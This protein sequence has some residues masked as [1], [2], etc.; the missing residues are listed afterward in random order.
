MARIGKRSTS[1]GSW[2]ATVAA[3]L[4]LGFASNPRMALGGAAPENAQRGE[5][6]FEPQTPATRPARAPVAGET[7]QTLPGDP[8]AVRALAAEMGRG[9]RP[10]STAHF[11]VVTDVDAVT[12]ARFIEVVEPTYAEVAAFVARLNLR[13]HPVRTKLIVVLFD[14]WEDY[15]RAAKSAG[16]ATDA[17]IAGYYDQRSNRSVMFNFANADL[18]RAK[19]REAADARRRLALLEAG[20]PAGAGRP[21]APSDDREPSAAALRELRARI[22]EMEARIEELERTI[23]ETVVRHEIAHQVLANMGVQGPASR[24]RRWLHEGLAMQ[25]ETPGRL[26]IHRLADCRAALQVGRSP[27]LRQLVG[28]PTTI[29]PGAEGAAAAY[30]RAWALVRYLAEHEP[31]ALAEYAAAA[32]GGPQGGWTSAGLIAEFEAAFGPLDDAFEGRWKQYVRGM[33]GETG[34]TRPAERVR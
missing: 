30:A 2:P 14:R 8:V 17:S 5:E 20:E 31:K 7:S 22:E 12:L 25:F 26:N 3:A 28:D 13:R 6:L 21:T 9:F 1:A 29:G 32:G 23:V 18:L 24:E 10:L 11:T 27:A 4:A 16:M 15:A 19:R 34:S 33:G